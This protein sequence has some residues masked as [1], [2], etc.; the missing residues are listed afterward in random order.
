M[1]PGDFPGGIIDLFFTTFPTFS[2]RNCRATLRYSLV[3]QKS[4]V[5]RSAILWVSFAGKGLDQMINF[6]Y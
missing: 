3:L 5:V 4:E 1:M 6:P 2:Y